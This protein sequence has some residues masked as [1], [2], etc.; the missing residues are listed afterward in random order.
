LI[1][2]GVATQS[3]GKYSAA[4]GCFYFFL[5]YRSGMDDLKKFVEQ[6]GYAVAAERM[7]C[8]YQRIQQWLRSGRIPAERAIDVE[9]TLGIPRHRLRPDLWPESLWLPAVIV[10]FVHNA[11][12][13]DS[14][15]HKTTPAG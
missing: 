11:G 13:P 8:R 6:N 7:G 5:W 4:Y 14:A 1:F 10:N 12:Q 9:R 15:A 3:T 2:S